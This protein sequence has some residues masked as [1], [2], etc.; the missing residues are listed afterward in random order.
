MAVTDPAAFFGSTDE[1]MHF[2]GSEF[3]AEL[4]A[5]HGSPAELRIATRCACWQRETGV[6]DPSC[7][8]CWPLGFVYDAPQ[9]VNVFGPNRKPTRRQDAAGT[10]DASDAYFTLPTGVLP[11]FG[12]RITLPLSEIIVD[13]ILTKGSE[14]IT[15][16]HRV[17]ELQEAHYVV[18]VPPTGSPYENERRDL[19]FTGPVP[20]L[21]RNDRTFTWNP[22]IV[23]PI[24]DG[25]RYVVRL[26]VLVEYICWEFQERNENGLP[27]PGRMLGKR[28]DYLHHPRGAQPLQPAA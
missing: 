24:P 27:L 7:R 9:V 6:P 2:D 25:T 4:L 15:R 3:D 11:T 8:L 22:A 23:P 12:S 5:M 1:A 21:T 13:D 28:V 14:D 10:Y 16:Y 17:L 18:R 19:V 20:H 26:K